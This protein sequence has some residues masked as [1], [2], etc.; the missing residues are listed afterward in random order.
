MKCYFGWTFQIGISIRFWVIKWSF[1]ASYNNQTS[2]TFQTF[3]MRCVCVCECVCTCACVCV[4]MCMRETDRDQERDRDT[5]TRQREGT[6]MVQCF[7]TARQVL[8]HWSTS[9]APRDHIFNMRHTIY[10][11]DIPEEDQKSSP[12]FVPTMFLDSWFV[13]MYISGSDHGFLPSFPL[14]S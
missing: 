11:A 13:S 12:K 3:W 6:C 5:K 7:L 10:S 14:C 2:Q 1:K 8:Y 9:S 4:C